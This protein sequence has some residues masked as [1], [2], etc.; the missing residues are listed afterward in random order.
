MLLLLLLPLLLPLLLLTL[1]L[2][3]LLRGHVDPEA[4]QR[5]LQARVE[6]GYRYGS[7]A[8]RTSK[9]GWSEAKGGAAKRNERIAR[10]RS[11]G[12]GTVQRSA[13]HTG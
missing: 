1:L 9:R 6:E 4:S 13:I 3:L 2:D 12:G 8:A 7:P 5:A 10:Q 11:Q